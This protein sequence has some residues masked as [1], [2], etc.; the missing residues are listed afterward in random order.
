MDEEENKIL[1]ELL[2]NL[3]QGNTDALEGIAK[4]VEPIL[5]AIGSRDYYN[6]ADAEDVVHKLYEKLVD[7]AWKF[8]ENTNACAWIITLFKNLV[9]ADLRKR[10]RENKLINDYA[11]LDLEQ[12]TNYDEA[13]IERHL[14]FKEISEQLTKEELDLIEYRYW[15]KA[16]V[17]EIASILHK[18]KSTV[19]YKLKKLEE[20]LKTLS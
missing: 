4:R 14:F 17:R 11:A 15:S 9:K 5:L 6:Y 10:K 12:R 7:N 19:E 16:T 8:K 2:F 18:P 1:G 13:Y 3:A 20:K